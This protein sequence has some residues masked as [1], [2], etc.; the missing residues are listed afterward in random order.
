MARGE[1]RSDGMGL[2]VRDIDPEIAEQLGCSERTVRRLVKRV[3]QRLTRM[4]E[5]S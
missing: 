5:E 3:Q 2:R 4:L 1:S